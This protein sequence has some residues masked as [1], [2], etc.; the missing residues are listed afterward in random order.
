MITTRLAATQDFNTRQR[1]NQPPQHT[2]RVHDAGNSK[3]T[4]TDQVTTQNSRGTQP[5]DRQ[6]VQSTA[7]NNTT[8]TGSSTRQG[9]IDMHFVKNS[10][11]I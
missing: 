8:E 11:Q 1:D 2:S 9:K 10:H 3:Q 6:A 7:G 4:N 5:G